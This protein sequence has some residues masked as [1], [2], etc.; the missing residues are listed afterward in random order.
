MAT[1]LRPRW[2][3][4]QHSA[5]GYE[6]DFTFMNGLETRRVTTLPEMTKVIKANGVLFDTYEAAEAYVEAEM[7]PPSS[8][9]FLVPYAR[10]TFA[11]VMIDQLSVYVPV[12]EVQVLT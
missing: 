8:P 12:A 11:D 9:H 1:K 3:A 7:Y 5:F 2:T 6:G 4:V 10:G